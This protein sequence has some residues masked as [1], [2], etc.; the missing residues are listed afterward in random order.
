MAYTMQDIRATLPKHKTKKWKKRNT[1]DTI[2]VHCTAG[3]N[4]DPVQTALYHITPSPDNH[5]CKTGAPGLAYHDFINKAGVLY[6]CNSYQDITWHA[7]LY[8]TRSIGVVMA[9]TGKAGVSPTTEQMKTLEEHLVFLC[10]CLHILPKNCIG[11]REVPGMYTIVGKG[12]KKFKKE[13]P[14]MMVDLDALRRRVTTR[15]QRVLTAKGLYSGPIDGD[16]GPLSK[17]ALKAYIPPDPIDWVYK[18]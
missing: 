7:G 14:G 2:V 17:A 11:H 9:Y 4:Q 8:N 18:D 5:L 10:L 1:A 3:D 15:L 16:F 12:L 6:R 13:C